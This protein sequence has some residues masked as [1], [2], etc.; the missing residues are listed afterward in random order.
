MS[1]AVFGLYVGNS[2]ASIAI[3]REGKVDILANEAGDRVTPSVVT[4][5]DKEEVVGAA[6]KSRLIS[7]ANSTIIKNKRALHSSL[8]ESDLERIVR[9]TKVEIDTSKDTILYKIPYGDNTKTIR[10]VQVASLILKTLY[11]IAKSAVH[12]DDERIS[13]VLL[14]P[15]YFTAESRKHLRSAAVDAGWNVLHVINEPC[16]AVLGYEINTNSPEHDIKVLVYR[17]GGISCDATLID[18]QHGLLSIVDNVHSNE[19]G[20]EKIVKTLMNYLQEEIQRK[21]KLDISD[22]GR[23]VAKLRQASETCMHVLSTLQSSNVFV[24]SLY[25]GL[26][27][28]HNVSRA[29]FES[30][31]GSLLSQFVQPIEDVLQKSGVSHDQIKKVLLIGGPLKIPKLQS[32]IKSLFPNAECPATSSI[33][34]DEILAAGAARQAGCLSELFDFEKHLPEPSMDVYVIGNSIEVK[35]QGL[36]CDDLVVFERNQPLPCFKK[37][38]LGGVSEQGGGG[39]GGQLSVEATQTDADGRLRKGSVQFENVNGGVMNLTVSVTIENKLNFDLWDEKSPGHPIQ[40]R[41]LEL[42]VCS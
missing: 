12:I 8:S 21:Y 40:S 3:Y 15:V 25:D 7:Q 42:Q 20:G 33:N 37:L 16:A 38:P 1:K 9:D 26:D 29:R 35:V 24:E 6:A 36:S 28:N 30:L 14:S 13:C 5:S 22:S 23:S 17:C 32:H 34:P 4:F 19:L 18:I 41:P 39:G 10:P 31:I 2:S 11:A 27:F